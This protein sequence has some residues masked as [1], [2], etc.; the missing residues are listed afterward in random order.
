MRRTY[1]LLDAGWVMAEGRAKMGEMLAKLSS[2]GREPAGEA[3]LPPT[4]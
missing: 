1:A 2:K 4:T 3:D